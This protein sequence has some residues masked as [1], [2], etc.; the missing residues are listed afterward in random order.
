M[1]YR[2]TLGR[3]NCVFSF[4][5]A[6]QCVSYSL[7]IGRFFFFSN[8]DPIRPVSCLKLAIPACAFPVGGTALLKS[9][10]IILP[11]HLYPASIVHRCLTSGL[12]NMLL[13]LLGMP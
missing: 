9:T 4:W 5:Q 13:L 3:I 1:S 7:N 12:V 6:G 10:L 8:K 2:S 11:G